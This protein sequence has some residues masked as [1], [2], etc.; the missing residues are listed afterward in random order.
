MMKLHAGSSS[1]RFL[2]FSR[3]SICPEVPGHRSWD[4]L[5]LIA[6][7][8]AAR[9]EDAGEVPV[10]ALV[11]DEK[12]QILSTAHNTCIRDCD[13]SAHAEILALRGAG[14]ALGNYRLNGC[15][16]VVTLEPCVMCA[17][18]IV[19]ARLAGLVIGARDSCEGAVVSSM[20]PLITPECGGSIWY[21]G[22]VLGDMCC[23]RLR[24]FFSRRR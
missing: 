23:T 11:I 12:G 13:V 5:M 21:M 2:P 24:R 15:F 18:A 1:E 14:R 9:G 19:S 6:D 10:G 4:E 16:L 3:D 22:G 20:A 17:Q 8:E 7:S